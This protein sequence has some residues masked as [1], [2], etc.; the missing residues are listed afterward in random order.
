MHPI[1]PD[2][3][4]KHVLITG[5][6]NGIG[7]ALTRS[8]AEQ[9]ALVTILDKDEKKGLAIAKECEQFGGKVNVYSVDLTDTSALSE[10]LTQ[11]RKERPVVDVLINN[12]GY[13]PRYPLLEM[14]E[15]QWNDLFQ[16][17]VVHYFVTCR[18]LLPDMIDAG[19]GS[20]IMTS[21]HVVWVAKPDMIAYDTTKA[22]IIGMVRGLAQA[23]GKHHIRVNAVAPGWI[24]TERQLN[25]WVTPEAK[26]KNLHEQQSIP[27]ELT[28]DE[29]VGT[30]LFLA[31]D[32]SR[33]ITRQTLV[34]DGGYAQS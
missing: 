21:S 26:H 9:A 25:Q 24:M 7:E 28:P 12:A 8:F 32:T 20:I 16:L 31:S 2:L 11:I 34:V 29:L 17:N 13:D 10:T 6:S 30:Y 22:A 4:D 14:S 23:V 5:G 18:E 15:Q 33:A 27:I 1:Y 3:K 19:R